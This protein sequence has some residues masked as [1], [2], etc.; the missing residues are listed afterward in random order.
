MTD[1]AQ[2]LRTYWQM[3][4]ATRVHLQRR[5]QRR[6]PDA[7]WADCEDAVSE[8]SLRAVPYVPLADPA[9]WLLLVSGRCLKTRWKRRRR[10]NDLEAVIR[11]DWHGSA[12]HVE[13]RIEA[14]HDGAYYLSC[15]RVKARTRLLDTLLDA[16][17][18]VAQRRGETVD[19][20]AENTRRAR[21]VLRQVRQQEEAR[22]AS[23]AGA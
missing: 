21:G 19:G 10:L 5:L 20:L 7:T 2:P 13:R 8:A 9:T 18:T 17:D 23:R 14:A 12:P 22:W 1:A 3:I 4:A 15:L 16:Y 11:Q 6:Y